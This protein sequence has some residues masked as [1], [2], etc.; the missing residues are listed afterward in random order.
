MGNITEIDKNFKVE[1]DIGKDDVVFF[2]VL[3]EPFRIYGVIYEDGMFRRMPQSVADSVSVNVGTLNLHTAGGRVRFKTDSPYVAIVVKMNTVWKM[4]HFAMTGASGFDMYIKREQ[5]EVYKNTFMPPV[6]LVDGYNS[7]LDTGDTS[8]KEI[9]INFP[10]Y[11]GVSSLYIG[12]AKDAKLERA[13]D[14]T[15]EKP[16]VFYGSSITQGGCASRPG[17]AYEGFLGRRFDF[18]HINLGF[19]GNAKGEDSIADYVS[20][21]DMSMFVYDYD[22]NAPNPEHLAAT[23]EKMFKKVR[24][25]HPDMPIIM[26]TRP[27]IYLTDEEVRRRKVVEQTYR[28]AMA[29]GDKNVYCIIGKD[30]MQYTDNEG[31]VDN[32]H[33]NDLG[34]ASMSKVIGDMIE[35]M[36]LF[37]LTEAEN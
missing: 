28:N 34:F 29:A 32:C 6:D 31:S 27:R 1:A 22:H 11:S 24:A 15:I 2:D 7:V 20:G 16:V 14:Y 30:L 5:R 25:A 9:T 12:L 33:P 21:L 8:M 37:E 23:H 19:A 13:E 35:E 10:L 18:N 17:N 4:Q 3:D 36:G 26:L